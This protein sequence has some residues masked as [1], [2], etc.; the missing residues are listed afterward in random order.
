MVQLHAQSTLSVYCTVCTVRTVCTRL[1]RAL[2]V[3]GCLHGNCLQNKGSI[4]WSWW[5]Q[6]SIFVERCDEISD[7]L[8]SICLCHREH[9]NDL[10]TPK[11][12]NIKKWNAL[13]PVIPKRKPAKNAK[14]IY[15]TK[16]TKTMGHLDDEI[17]KI[18]LA[19]SCRIYVELLL[20]TSALLMKR[21]NK[22]L[23]K[24]LKAMFQLVHSKSENM[25]KEAPN[26]RCR[27]RSAQIKTQM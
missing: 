17:E 4:S 12:Q 27:S 8:L 16:I 7:W 15:S 21:L 14:K 18:W 24:S 11:A 5:S 25:P 23:P 22:S 2:C 1:L 20:D 10:T 3:G 19:A 13:A 6:I 9:D 26:K